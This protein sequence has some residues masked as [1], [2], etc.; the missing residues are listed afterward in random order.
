MNKTN[1]FLFILGVATALFTSCSSDDTLEASKGLE[2]TEDEKWVLEANSDEKIQLGSGDNSFTRAFVGEGAGENSTLFMT[3]EGIGVFCLASGKMDPSA[4]SIDWNQYT[5]S[6]LTLRNQGRYMNWMG[7]NTGATLENPDATKS[8][9][10]VTW[11]GNVYANAY[12]PHEDEVSGEDVTRI[13]WGD[14]FTRFYPMGNWYTYT[15]Y[16]YHPYQ[17]DA[18]KVKTTAN[19]VDVTIAIDGFTDVL[20]GRSFRPSDG[21]TETADN[22]AYSG[23]YFRQYRKAHK[24][25][26]QPEAPT[27]TMAFK[28][29]LSRINFMV[30]RGDSTAN[31]G[32]I[33]IKELK[34]LG[35]VP[36]SV[37][38][39]V[40]K[41][42]VASAVKPTDTGYFNGDPNKEEG[43][44]TTSSTTYLTT[45]VPDGFKDDG[46]INYLDDQNGVDLPYA[47]TY[48]T[49]THKNDIT[50]LSGVANA[51][52]QVTI[53][54][55]DK[56]PNYQQLGTGI[57]VPPTTATPNYKVQLTIVLERQEG[58][59]TKTYTF[60]PQF[61][62]PISFAGPLEQ[63]KQYNVRITVYTPQD[64]RINAELVDWDDVNV[65]E[66]S[67]PGI[68]I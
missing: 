59:D 12:Q 47:V 38:L 58:G 15:F 40:A 48:N 65:G 24:D 19:S 44:V 67:E 68:E 64:I 1:K 57:I 8:T 28:H 35:D 20:W 14:S 60:I 18:N 50:K 55:G 27:P 53:N 7:M 17:W 45:S 37:D 31:S 34:L 9:N 54:K 36:N 39:N 23:K 21:T 43:K 42:N 49:E 2:L 62:Y 52:R 29:A 3:N 22:Y 66:G 6:D 25:D 5:S 63:G 16:G 4:P 10:F 41:L 46:S 61:P 13:S 51:K 56:T 11:G 33:Y 26:V 32:S 30:G